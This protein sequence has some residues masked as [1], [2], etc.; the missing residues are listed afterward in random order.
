M[1]HPQKAKRLLVAAECVL[2]AV[3]AA[4][5]LWPGGNVALPVNVGAQAAGGLGLGAPSIERFDSRAALSRAYPDTAAAVAEGLDWNRHS[6][7]RVRWTA[8]GVLP[9]DRAPE[10]RQVLYGELKQRSRCLGRELVFYVTSPVGYGNAGAV[11]HSI[12]HENW[13]AIAR[14][15][16]VSFADP[17]ELAVRDGIFWLA[18]VICAGLIWATCRARSTWRCPAGAGTGGPR[19]A[20]SQS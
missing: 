20:S 6:L 13:F 15:A 3:L 18:T 4:W 9:L 16:S 12:W 14:P 10:Q 8:N 2:V 19:Y 7:V 17:W 11:F 5:Y 1:N